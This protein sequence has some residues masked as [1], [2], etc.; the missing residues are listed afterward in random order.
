MIIQVVTTIRTDQQ[1][2]E[3]VS[4]PILGFALTDLSS[5]F[6]DLLPDYTVN[7][8]LMDVFENQPV[9]PVIIDPL[10]ILIRFGISFE[11]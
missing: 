11:V 8:G 10:L 5:L 6:L 2:A 7:D 1:T 4:L 3:N 9:L